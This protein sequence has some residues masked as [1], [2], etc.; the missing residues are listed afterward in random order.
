MSME[1]YYTEELDSEDQID[2][3]ESIAALL[4]LSDRPLE[5][6]E[7]AQQFARDILLKVLT[8]FR[9]DLVNK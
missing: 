7:D 9:P 6:E 5:S 1:G 3:E 4:W 8:K 2:M